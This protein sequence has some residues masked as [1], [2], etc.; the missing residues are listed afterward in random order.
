MMKIKKPK[1]IAFVMVSY[2]PVPPRVGE[3]KTKPT[4]FAVRTMLETGLMPD[5][6]VGRSEMDMDAKRKEKLAFSCMIDPRDIISAPD[7]DSVYDVPNKFLDEGFDKRILTKLG[8]NIKKYKKNED[9][10]SAWKKFVQSSRENKK[11]VKIAVVGKYFSTGNF[12]LSDAY[13]SVIEAL[14]YS[15]YSLGVKAELTWVD[16]RQ[17]E[18][19]PKSVSILKDY[20]G[21]LVP[22][23]FGSTGIE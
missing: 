4:Q 14:K 7:M 15:A 23:G 22:G 10:I 5:F 8:I 12:V 3:M 13:V 16:S 19:K 11:T 18:Q 21:I 17:F 1:D 9:S 2:L 6:I 20:D